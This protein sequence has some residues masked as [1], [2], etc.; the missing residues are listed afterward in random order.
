MAHHRTPKVKRS[1]RQILPAAR[2]AQN[3]F[4]DRKDSPLSPALRSLVTERV[5]QINHCVFCIDIN[6]AT[7]QKLGV[8]DE[9]ID[10]LGRL[11][12]EQ[13]VDADERLE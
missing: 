5:S 9:K 11:A 6:S 13:A 2:E 7:L 8:S 4:L 12:H 1:D 10:A 3:D